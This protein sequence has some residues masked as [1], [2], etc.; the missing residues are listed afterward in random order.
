MTYAEFHMDLTAHE[1]RRLAA[2]LAATPGWDPAAALAD[3]TRA[4]RM[5]YSN[6]DAEQRAV[7]AQLREAGVL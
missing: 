1:G 6:L 3:E 7:L 5:L 4:H 2:V